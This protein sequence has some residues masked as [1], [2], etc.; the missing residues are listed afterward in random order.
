MKKGKARQIHDNSNDNQL[1]DMYVDPITGAKITAPSKSPQYVIGKRLYGTKRPFSPGRVFTGKH[2]N[3]DRKLE[4]CQAQ[5]EG[6][7]RAASREPPREVAQPQLKTIGA[8]KRPTKATPKQAPAS[9]VFGFLQDI[10]GHLD[11]L[12]AEKYSSVIDYIEFLKGGN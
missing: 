3:M 6:Y 8:P 5:F 2:E 12:P 7:F 11:G 9:N 4:K 10:L 1:V